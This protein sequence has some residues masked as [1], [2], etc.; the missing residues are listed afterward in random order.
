[1]QPTILRAPD[2]YPVPRSYYVPFIAFVA[3]RIE[4]YE[5]CRR[6][7]VPIAM[8]MIAASIALMGVAP[9]VANQLEAVKGFV[10]LCMFGLGLT[11]FSCGT[12]LV[13]VYARMTSSNYPTYNA[14]AMSEWYLE[15]DRHPMDINISETWIGRGTATLRQ[16]L[17]DLAAE[18]WKEY[19]NDPCT[20]L[21]KSYSRI[22]AWFRERRRSIRD[23]QLEHYDAALRDYENALYDIRQTDAVA[24][25]SDVEQLFALHII[26]ADK[27]RS[28]RLM[29]R[30]L[31][32]ACLFCIG[33]VIAG[34]T[35][36]F[37]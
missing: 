14:G 5:R 10:A 26:R 3:A 30:I 6:S 25:R 37:R 2:R 7:F 12:M 20:T 28:V 4:Y 32:V 34:V 19:N 9:A 36:Y 8:G 22:F 1:M 16:V 11:L 21:Q 29:A 15:S 18:D 27:R 24:T 31:F 13:Y 35:Y 23:R 17:Q 33:W